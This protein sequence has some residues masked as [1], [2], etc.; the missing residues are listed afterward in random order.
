MEKISK[1]INDNPKMSMGI[2]VFVIVFIIEFN[3]MYLTA[4]NTQA[5]ER[6]YNASLITMI[7]FIVYSV[8]VLFMFII[9]K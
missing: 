6:V 3:I 4:Y 9:K 5:F 2:G 7:G 8:V 1:F